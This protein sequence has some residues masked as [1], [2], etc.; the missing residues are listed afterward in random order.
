MKIT[1]LLLY[2]RGFTV[3]AEAEFLNVTTGGTYQWALSAKR[4]ILSVLIPTLLLGQFRF[5][6]PT[7][8]SVLHEETE[9]TKLYFI[10]PCGWLAPWNTIQ[11]LSWHVVSVALLAALFLHR[12][13]I[14]RADYRSLSLCMYDNIFVYWNEVFKLNI[15]NILPKP[16][17]FWDKL[18]HEQNKWCCRSIFRVYFSYA[19]YMNYHVSWVYTSV[20]YRPMFCLMHFFIRGPYGPG[21][22]IYYKPRM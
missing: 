19:T 12:L 1:R 18:N 6:A 13:Y 16:A 20:F 5:D 11:L 2:R 22:F 14:V 15:L 3:L 7:R 4:R 10:I 9:T 21:I 17:S 8:E